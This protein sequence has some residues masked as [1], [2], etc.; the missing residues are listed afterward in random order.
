MS[1]F[2][3]LGLQ[4]FF[5]LFEVRD[6]PVDNILQGDVFNERIQ[7][8]S[9]NLSIAVGTLVAYYILLEIAD[10]A[11]F[12]ERAHTLV[13]RVSIAVDPLAERASQIRQYL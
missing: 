9:S 13:D 11:D 2:Q 4:L 6:H 7:R 10:D 1:F 5:A 8:L 3:Q 12:T